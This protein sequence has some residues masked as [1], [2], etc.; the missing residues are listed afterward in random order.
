MIKTTICECF[1]YKRDTRKIDR[2]KNRSSEQS[3]AHPTE[4]PV[5]TSTKRRIVFR[6]TFVG[7]SYNSLTLSSTGLSP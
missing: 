7:I 3:V 2:L 1:E 6:N 4:R 5:H